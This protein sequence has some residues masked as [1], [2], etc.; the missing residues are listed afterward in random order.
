MMLPAY[1]YFLAADELK[2]RKQRPKDYPTLIF[3]HF[4]RESMFDCVMIHLRRLNDPDE[5]SLA[6]GTIA[7]LLAQGSVLEFLLERAKRLKTVAKRLRLGDPKLHL[8]FVQMQCSQLL[9]QH[10]HLLPA[11]A[12]LPQIQAFLARRTANKRS[13]HMT[14]DDWAI[15]SSDIRDLVLRAAIIARAIQRVL[16]SDVYP[17]NYRDVDRGAYSSSRA[18]F[19]VRHGSGLLLI[20]LEAAVDRG[21][22]KLRAI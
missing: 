12:P 13:A 18:L 21:V 19:G 17:G 9:I 14:L 2:R 6:G 8:R 3:R 5:R 7:A 20:G 10:A 22:R 11:N 15:T 16:G 4:M 1:H